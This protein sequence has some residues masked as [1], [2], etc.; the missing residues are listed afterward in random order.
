MRACQADRRPQMNAESRSLLVN[1]CDRRGNKFSYSYDD[2]ATLRDKARAVAELTKGALCVAAHEV[3]ADD[4]RGRCGS[5][6]PLLG[7]VAEMARS[8]N[9]ALFPAESGRSGIVKNKAVAAAIAV[10]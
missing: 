6:A 2:N 1:V 9:S 3:Q 10:P 8:H 5:T 7:A 4:L